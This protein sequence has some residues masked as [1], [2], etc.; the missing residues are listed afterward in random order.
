VISK[1]VGGAFGGKSLLWPGTILTV[2][3]ARVAKRPVK[4]V[5]TREGVFRTVG[6][7][8]PSVQRVALGAMAD[9]RRV[10]DLPISIDK[11]L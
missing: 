1:F 4:L 8:T 9:G 3:A 11:L 10:V 6:G 5:L 7:R 2:L